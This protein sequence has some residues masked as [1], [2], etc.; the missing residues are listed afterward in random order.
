MA[1]QSTELRAFYGGE[2]P[3]SFWLRMVSVVHTTPWLVAVQAVRGLLWGLMALLLAGTL[4][5]P[6]W[7]AA[8]LTAGV[9]MALFALP[10]AIPNPFMPEAVRQM[11]LIETVLSRGLYGFIAV[12]IVRPYLQPVRLES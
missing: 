9:F 2:D 7:S 6:R 5:G 12:W 11:H 1:W 10:L 3:G 4:S 8:L